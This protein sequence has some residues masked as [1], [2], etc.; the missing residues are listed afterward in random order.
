[1]TVLTE[2]EV[3]DSSTDNIKGKFSLNL[4][5]Q[6]RSSWKIIARN[7]IRIRTSSFRNHRRL[8]FIALYSLLVIWAVIIAPYLFDLFIPTLAVQFSDVFKP[9]VA[10]TIES[11][12]MMLFLVLVIYPL[13][14]I[15]K[16]NEGATKE[17]LLATPVKENDIFLGE[18]LGKSPI[19][20]IA[21]LILAPIIVGLI[22][23]IIELTLIQYVV[24]YGTVFGHVYFANLI[25]SIIASWFEHKISKNEKA[26]DLGKTL[27]WVFTI[28]LVV[29]MY[30]VMFFLNFLLE[31][32]ELKNWLAFYPSLWFSNIILYS[33]DPVLLNTFILNIWISVL[34]AV[35]IP[36]ITL[37]VSYKKAES[38]YTLEGGIEKSS[39]TIIEHENLFYVLV[40]KISGRKWGGLIVLQLK[41]FFR[42][43]A[44]IARVA[45]V[46]GLL[47]FMSWFISRMNDDAFMTVFSS[48]ILI[49]M[50]GGIGSIIIGHLAFVDS[51]DL[52]WVYKRSPRGIKAIVY[53]YLLMMLILNVFL[54]IFI[55]TMLT[56]FSNIDLLNTVIFF[57]EF[58]L[59]AQISMC[60]AMGLQC[61]S[62]AF[63]EKDSSMK[64]NAMISMLL[65]Q[66]LLFLPIGL[67]VFFRPRS[68]ELLRLV[69]QIPLFLYIIGVSLP[70]LYFG[71]KK[72]NKLE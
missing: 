32:P 54:T 40:R 29:I 17:T 63:G 57:I 48:T 18:F 23:P 15:Y 3:I 59:F 43:K 42:K 31:H 62:P 2:E 45:Y 53:S 4:A 10:I 44:N 65:L 35:G 71:M 9:V 56:I 12:M 26:R 24:I 38:F 64:G 55:T 37:Y 50:G 58:L 51:K 68:I 49:A 46:V 7:E 8:F 16:E 28:I 39:V 20:S 67:L 5:H 30:A 27:I 61:I 66:P 19:Y 11:I 13:N 25:G 1:M 34:L 60:Q 41:R 33:I 70:I 21:I 6:K 14:N 47:G 36:I 72:L 69:L 52:I 22:N